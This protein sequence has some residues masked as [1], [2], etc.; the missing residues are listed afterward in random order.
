MD[1]HGTRALDG[2][3]GQWSPWTAIQSRPVRIVLGF[4][5]FELAY[6]C[7]YQIGMSFDPVVAAPFWF[8]DA[9]LLCGLL[10]TR[11]KWWW[12][13]LVAILPVRLLVAV[14]IDLQP[15]FLGAVYV[16]DCAKGVL[17]ALLL[18]RFL[19]DPIRLQSMRDLG[20]YVLFAVALVPALSA[21]A[22]AAT[23][24]GMGQ[25]FWPSFEQWL[26]G[27]ALASLVVTPILFYWVLRPPNPATFSRPRIIEAALLAIGLHISL[28]FAFEPTVD[29]RDIAETRF[30]APVPFMVW[31][32]IRF[33]MFGATAVAAM[34]SVFAVDAAIDG[35]GSF[36]NIS[37]V[38]MSSRLQHFLL[39]RIAPLYL[40]AVLIEQW[41]RV[42]NSL[43]DSEQ[44]FR[45]IADCAPVMMWTS[46]TDG[47]QDFSNRGWLAFTGRTFEES[48]GS[49]WSQSVHPDD[50]QRTFD[51]YFNSFNER[52]MLELEFRVRRY[53]GEYRWVYLRGAP[54]YGA[55]R[56]FMGYVGSAIDLTERRQQEA[57]LKRSEARY[58][59]VVESQA[60]FVCR[61]LPDGTLTFINSAYCRFL[62]RERLDLLGEN[63]VSLLPPLARGA[64]AEALRRA[65]ES[66]GDAAWECEVAHADGTRGWQSWVCHAIE[67]APD[68]TR[69]LQVIGNDVTDR[70]RAEESGRQLAQA[71]RFAA[72][73]EL[74]AI[75]AHEINQPLCAILSNAEAA[76][77]LLRSEHPPLD[78]L[79]EIVADIRKDDLRADEAIRGIRSLLRRR[80]FE[81]RPVDLVATIQ[82]VFK[83]IGG[84]ALHR[85]VTIRH[86]LAE[87]LPRVTGD[88]SSI[89]QVLVILMVNGMD[90]MKE[91]PEAAREL[92]VSAGRQ[93]DDFV[94]VTVRDRGHGIAAAS[95]AQLFE[96]FFT[97]KTD[98]MGMGL[99]IAR[100][101][102][103]AHG[104]RI[105]AENAPDGGA[106]F[107]FTLAVAQIPAAA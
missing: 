39:L 76:E 46:G 57:A 60:N 66:T 6:I 55:N 64:T 73:G 3:A 35:T 97:T 2:F 59:D 42:S 95:M 80:E 23:R 92:V 67:A 71:T 20:V 14:P 18:R 104:G 61:L 63:F 96:S 9:V 22:G 50:L 48:L 56:E 72:V 7:A 74:T 16:N 90:A 91:T 70:K 77:I 29:P 69:E 52:R 85:R 93:G 1:S 32:A 89:E 53:D 102:I 47:G 19:V 10:C 105:W 24:A 98:G 65:L 37:S 49:R 12:L 13:L 43:R 21:L 27:D 25:P 103:D 36:A 62:G 17:A 84:D 15:W 45:N 58:R 28:K 78:E 26:L 99:S 33:R 87:G 79:R 38:E 83:L 44:R 88:R 41:V 4:C 94:E 82:H 106:A 75:V 31:A 68:E 51:E 81:P 8:P 30:Y 11:P 5:A 101:M 86:D 100:S 40:A 54:R 34:L 107:R